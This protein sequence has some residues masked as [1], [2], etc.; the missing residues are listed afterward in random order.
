MSPSLLNIFDL[1]EILEKL[2]I[3]FFKDNK[4]LFLVDL[5]VILLKLILKLIVTTGVRFGI[6]VY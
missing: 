5:M 2:F 1:K 3:E 6:A 4:E